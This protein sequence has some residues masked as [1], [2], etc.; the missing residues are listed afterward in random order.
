[1]PFKLQFDDHAVALNR[2]CAQDQAVVL[3]LEGSRI[4]SADIIR[5]GAY[6]DM[7]D[8]HV[9]VDGDIA[10]I[11]IEFARDRSQFRIA[12]AAET[13]KAM[14]SNCATLIEINPMI[15]RPKSARTDR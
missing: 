2:R 12:V 14:S 10:A 5:I 8:D 13:R 1:M 7:M 9:A 3:E 6:I 15:I 4:F 11:G